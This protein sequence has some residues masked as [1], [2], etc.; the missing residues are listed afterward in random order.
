MSTDLH[1]IAVRP[2]NAPRGGQ[3]LFLLPNEIC[4]GFLGSSAPPWIVG[5]GI[6]K[7]LHIEPHRVYV[8]TLKGIF[9]TVFRRLAELTRQL[10]SVLPN[11]FLPASRSCFVNALKISALDIA[12]RVPLLIFVLNEHKEILVVSRR[13]WPALREWLQVPRGYGASAGGK[14]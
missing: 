9:S 3:I 12:G 10:E 2:L 7:K 5:F 4:Y 13:A 11:V 8:R 6:A 1:L 14:A